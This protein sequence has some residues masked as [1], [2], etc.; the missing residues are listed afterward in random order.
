MTGLWRWC[1]S[2]TA[3]ARADLVGRPLA[4]APVQRLA[5]GTMSLIAHTVSSIG[6]SGS[7]RWQ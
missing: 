6:V 2:A 1:R 5:R 4:R 3:I 7:A